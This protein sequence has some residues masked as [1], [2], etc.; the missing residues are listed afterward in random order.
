VTQSRP[1]LLIVEGNGGLSETLREILSD[2]Y[3]ITC[4]AAATAA[5]ATLKSRRFDIVLLD[6]S[7]PDGRGDAVAK[8][9]CASGVPLVIISGDI[10][11]AEAEVAG[12][13]LT[14]QKPFGL[15]DMLVVLAQA[16]RVSAMG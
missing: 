4:V 8:Q 11:F 2:N 7:L 9:I 16:L 3:R 6:Y 5:L 15:D 1:S 10:G 13:H 14:L 12:D